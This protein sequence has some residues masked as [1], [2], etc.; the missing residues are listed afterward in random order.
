MVII[1]NSKQQFSNISYAP[2]F[3]YSKNLIQE[4]I[5]VFV[6]S[7]S[8][9]NDRWDSGEIESNKTE[10]L[11]GGGNNL[12]AG[13]KYFVHISVFYKDHGWSSVQIQEFIQPK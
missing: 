6:G 11:Y 4:K 10:I 8:G 3:T 12:I 5:R 1:Y 9:Q 13:Q 2:R 7:K